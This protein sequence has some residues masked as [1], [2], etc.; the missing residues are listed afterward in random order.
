[1]ML[2]PQIGRVGLHFRV[3]WRLRR[4]VFGIASGNGAD[5][6]EEDRRG[7]VVDYLLL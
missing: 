2:A 6:V 7:F 4:V 3:G 1:M 5:G